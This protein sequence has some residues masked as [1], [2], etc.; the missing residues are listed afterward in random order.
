MKSHWQEKR[1][2]SHGSESREDPHK[3]SDQ[4]PHKAEEKVDRLQ[5]NLESKEEM[6]KNIHKSAGI[7]FAVNSA[8]DPRGKLNLKPDLKHQIS[9]G[10]HQNG[11]E[12]DG[13]EGI[14]LFYPEE[15]KEKREGAEKKAQR[16]Q[17]EG[18]GCQKD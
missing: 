3:G 16:P 5:G 14:T 6:L 1:N 17:K 4:D 18:I 9:A 13:P 8:P 7:R 11:D 15:K 2:R 10:R 12:Q